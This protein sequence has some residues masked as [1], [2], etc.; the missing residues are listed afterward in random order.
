MDWVDGVKGGGGWEWGAVIGEVGGCR[1]EGWWG[2]LGG[3]IC[4]GGR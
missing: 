1:V 2:Y 3:S 4:I